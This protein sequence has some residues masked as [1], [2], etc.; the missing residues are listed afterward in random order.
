MKLEI[1][2]SIY[3][4]ARQELA[5]ETGSDPE[6]LDKSAVLAWIESKIMDVAC[7]ERPGYCDDYL[8]D[9][10][11]ARWEGKPCAFH[12]MKDVTKPC[13]DCPK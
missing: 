3:K 10:K 5:L 2:G 13:E 7:A 12:E 9:G 4:L 6:S 11:C 1:K 8:K